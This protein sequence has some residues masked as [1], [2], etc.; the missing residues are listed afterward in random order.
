MLNEDHPEFVAERHVP[1]CLNDWASA[2]TV[3]RWAVG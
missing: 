3:P 2:P 1:L